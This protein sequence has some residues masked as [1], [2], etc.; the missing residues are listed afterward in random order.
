[1][2]RHDQRRFAQLVFG[3][4]VPQVAYRTDGENN[5]FILEVGAQRFFPQPYDL[6]RGEASSAEY[7]LRQ[8]VAIRR[9][10][11][12]GCMFVYPGCSPCNDQVI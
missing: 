11:A 8:F 12:G 1:M 9:D 3:E 7:A 4:S 10:H 6:L 5:L 2:C